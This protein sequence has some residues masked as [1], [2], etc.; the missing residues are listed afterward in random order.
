MSNARRLLIAAS[1]L[2][3]CL[4]ENQIRHA[5]YGTITTAVLGSGIN[6]EVGISFLLTTSTHSKNYSLRTS[7]VSSRVLTTFTPSVEYERPC[8]G[9]RIGG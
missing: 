8:Q 7:H 5:F 1:A 3:E 2:S 9:M 6:T 4:K